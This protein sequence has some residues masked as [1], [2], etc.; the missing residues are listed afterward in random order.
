MDRVA[1]LE[2]VEGLSVMTLTGEIDAFTAPTLRQEVHEVLADPSVGRLLIDLSAV[3]FMDSSALGAIVA[4][5]RRLRERNGE[6]W[7]VAPRGSAARIFE[8]TGLD[9]VL[10]FYPD[11]DAAISATIA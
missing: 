11:R 2:Q 8:L 1:S 9:T 7:L 3:T 6:L 10:E 4:A 5:L